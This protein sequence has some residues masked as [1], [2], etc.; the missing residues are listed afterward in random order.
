MSTN[1]NQRPAAETPAGQGSAAKRPFAKR[2]AFPMILFALCIVLG[3]YL[4]WNSS[5][6]K[7]GKLKDQG[8]AA[9][10]TYNDIDGNPVTMSEL[11]GKVR[12]VYFFYSNCPDVCPPTTFM[13]SEVQK[14]LKEDG[15]FGSKVDFLSITI[16]PERDTPEALKKFF[17][18][19]N[20]DYNGWKILRGDEKETAE[21]ARKYQLL[22][23]KDPKTGEFGHMNLIVVV[24]KKGRMRDFI[25]PESNNN[26]GDYDA[27]ALYKE[28][29][30][31]L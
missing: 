1:D 21:L 31:L 13:M 20:A 11:N 3:G 8:A 10:F 16:D 24:D 14:K 15:T 17:D 6:D 12:L 25:S 27:D 26:P 18:K 5:S 7:E 22:V 28:I 19:F 29:K 2:Y 23:S 30:S 4:I 9:D